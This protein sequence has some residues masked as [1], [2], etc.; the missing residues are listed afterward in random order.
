MRYPRPT[1]RDLEALRP[2]I[3]AE[4]SDAAIDRL[5]AELG[6]L[7]GGLKITI[8]PQRAPDLAEDLSRIA[9]DAYVADRERGYMRSLG[10]LQLSLDLAAEREQSLKKEYGESEVEIFKWLD[11]A[12]RD[13]DSATRKAR[14]WRLAAQLLMV[15]CFWLCVI[16]WGHRG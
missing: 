7:P 15:L 16:T 10:K 2:L 12:C 4:W 6:L 11:V 14:R 9:P 8:D 5:S 3:D 1:K 13:R